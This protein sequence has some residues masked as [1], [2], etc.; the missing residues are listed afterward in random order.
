MR[1]STLLLTCITAIL[2]VGALALVVLPTMTTISRAL[3]A[4]LAVA[5]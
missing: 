4:A 1:T 2:V 5:Q 3:T